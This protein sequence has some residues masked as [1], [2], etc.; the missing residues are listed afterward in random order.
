MLL[1]LKPGSWESPRQSSGMSVLRPSEGGV[2]RGQSRSLSLPSDSLGTRKAR[3]QVA[4]LRSLACCG[5]TTNIER[6]DDRHRGGRKEE[7]GGRG[8]KVPKKL[9]FFGKVNES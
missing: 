7:G 2:S 8:R 5:V 6:Q 3:S 1:M 9:T 4:D